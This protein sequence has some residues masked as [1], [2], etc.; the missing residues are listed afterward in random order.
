MHD[1]FTRGID[2]KTGRLRP[3]YKDVPELYKESALG[4]I[5]KNWYEGKLIDSASEEHYGFT[6]GP[7][8]SDLQTKHYTNSGVQVIQLQNIG[9]GEFINKS[10]VYTSNKKA[11]ELRSCNIYPSDIIIAKMADPVARACI[12][13]DHAERFVMASDGIRLRVDTKKHNTLFIKESI[14]NK[15]FRRQAVSKST[16]TT[17]ERIGLTELKNIK[18]KYPKLDEQNAI[19]KRIGSIDSLIRKESKN[20]IKHQKIKKG[21]MQDLLTGKVEVK[22]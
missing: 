19:A 7:F 10:V 1:L 12:I 9:D 5:P 15:Y 22:V 21:L 11:D 2:T 6:G 20:L 8:G 17:R 18:V 16:G 4:M 14:N 13:P 3:S